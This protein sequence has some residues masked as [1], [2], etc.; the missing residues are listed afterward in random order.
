MDV[1]EDWNAREM[2]HKK[3]LE[4]KE[5]R[6]RQLRSEYVWRECVNEEEA[7]KVC[8][9]RNDDRADRGSPAESGQGRNQMQQDFCGSPNNWISGTTST[10]WKGACL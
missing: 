3:R 5:I 8:L 7:M 6:Y 10:G 4:C 1:S 2:L 9:G